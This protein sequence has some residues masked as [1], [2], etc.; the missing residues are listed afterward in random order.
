MGWH[1]SMYD[2]IEEVRR[3]AMAEVKE[4]IKKDKKYMHPLNKERNEDMKRLGFTSGYEF[5]CWA[6]RNGILKNPTDIDREMRRT[7]VENAGCKTLKEYFDKCAQK[8]GFK[9]WTEKRR[10]WRYATGMFLP[11]EFNEDC[12]QWFGDFTENLMI[13]RYPGATKMPLNNRGFDYLWHGIKIDNKGRCICHVEGIYPRFIFQIKWNN[14]A[15]IFILSGWDNR[16][17]LNPLFALEFKK[18]DLIRKGICSGDHK[19]EFWKRDNFTMACN[20]KVLEQF[21]DYQIDITWLKEL[22][23]K[24]IE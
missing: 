3:N 15:D 17:S 14:I 5:I 7:T 22:C 6:Q 8:S 9:D 2:N 13:H 1:D 20:Q 16:E 10:E 21:K 4:K 11:R 12:S 24:K 19:V 23:N 18:N